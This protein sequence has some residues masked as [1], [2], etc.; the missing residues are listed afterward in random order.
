M[1]K[2]GKNEKH[3]AGGCGYINYHF[4]TFEWSAY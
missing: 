1:A 4:I 3:G 2:G